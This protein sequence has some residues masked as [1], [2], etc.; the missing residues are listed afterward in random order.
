MTRRFRGQSPPG[1]QR[2]RKRPHSDGVEQEPMKIVIDTI[3]I[4]E[5]PPT[6]YTAEIVI[7]KPHFTRTDE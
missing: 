7:D 2:N 6:D 5:K 1:Y 3:V 4:E